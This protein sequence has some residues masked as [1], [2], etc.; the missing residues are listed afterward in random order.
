M[1][2]LLSQLFI[3]ITHKRPQYL[4]AVLVEGFLKKVG[5]VPVFKFFEARVEVEMLLEELPHLP[6]N[7]LH[8]HILPA[9]PRMLG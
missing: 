8:G 4:L 9:S 2:L 1:F 5:W 6:E 3:K 7:P